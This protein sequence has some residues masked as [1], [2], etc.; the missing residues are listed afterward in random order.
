MNCG[1]CSDTGVIETG[2]NDLPCSCPAGSRAIFNVCEGSGMVQKT[3][4]E[5]RRE[6]RNWG[7]AHPPGQCLGC[8]LGPDPDTGHRAG[9]YY[10]PSCNKGPYHYMCAHDHVRK[11]MEAKK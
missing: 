4:M 11:C 10:C 9:A 6:S 1:K 7:D 8:S 2:N 5:I 3:G